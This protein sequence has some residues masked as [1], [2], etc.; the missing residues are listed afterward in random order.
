MGQKAQTSKVL[1]FQ[2]QIERVRYKWDSSDQ[3]GWV[4]TRAVF[5]KA[6]SLQMGDG[7]QERS[8]QI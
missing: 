8:E 3:A 1:T 7:D 4:W 5:G 2:G 6:G